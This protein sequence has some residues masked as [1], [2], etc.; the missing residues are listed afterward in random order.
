MPS[1]SVG[2]TKAWSAVLARVYEVSEPKIKMSKFHARKVVV[3]ANSF[4]TAY[5]Q[6][7]D[8]NMQI[9]LACRGTNIVTPDVQS[10]H[11]GSHLTECHKS[12]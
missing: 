4:D 8:F 3:F 12:P 7:G 5:L 6:V 1:W 10:L 9:V 11:G 2:I